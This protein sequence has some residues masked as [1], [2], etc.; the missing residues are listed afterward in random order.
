MD[1]NYMISQ[2]KKLRNGNT[3]V[4]TIFSEEDL[5]DRIKTAEDIL[6]SL[7]DSDKELLGNELSK[8]KDALKNACVRNERFNS[9]KPTLT[10]FPELDEH[11]IVFALQA[12][13]HIEDL[14]ADYKFLK[15]SLKENVS[16]ED[17]I[18]ILRTAITKRSEWV[19]DFL[20]K[21][22]VNTESD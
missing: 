6:S 16:H 19:D 1:S 15:E 2:R 21:H 9:G 5:Q 22:P 12:M 13:V 3:V 20:K 18:N 11:A 4:R 17:F 10:W 8:I 14:N 7:N